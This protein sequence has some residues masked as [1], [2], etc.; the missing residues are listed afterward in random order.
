[1]NEKWENAQKWE[2]DWH[3]NCINSLGEELKQIVY[4]EKLGLDF[5]VTPKTPYNINLQGKSILDIGSGPYSLLLKCSDGGKL[6]AVDPL[7]DKFGEWVNDRY[8]NCG[9][10]PMAKTGESLE[11]WACNILFDEVW[12]YNVLEHVE[13][14]QKI[15]ENAK[16][17]G[18]IVR[19]FEW[20]DSGLNIG[21][22]HILKEK[23]L[24]EWLGGTG[25]VEN[26]N[27]NGANGTAYYGIFKGNYY[28]KSL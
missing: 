25:K 28:E 16:R 1:M 26:I 15:V 7:M 8:W 9:V 17:L 11:N 18:K 27:K 22:I 6:V 3:G 21:H 12:I 14:P 2:N 5:N 20:V 19:I 13:N 23:K 10:E 24:N 4:A